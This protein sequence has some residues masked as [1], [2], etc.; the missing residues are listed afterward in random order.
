M[1]VAVK[2]FND[3]GSMTRSQTLSSREVTV[4]NSVKHENI[5]KLLGTEED[6]GIKVLE[7]NTAKV[8][9][10]LTGPP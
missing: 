8:N 2:C 5:V 9:S 3:A 6:V 4:M 10:L 1:M 7:A